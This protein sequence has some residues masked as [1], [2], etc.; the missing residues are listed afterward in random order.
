MIA[1]YKFR[2]YELDQALQVGDEREFDFFVDPHFAADL[3]APIYPGTLLVFANTL[4]GPGTPT[5]SHRCRIVSIRHPALGNVRSISTK[6][7]TYTLTLDDSSTVFVNAEE[8][9]GMIEGSDRQ[10]DDWAFVIEL[11]PLKPGGISH[12]DH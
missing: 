7:F 4:L 3:S 8:Q 5:V 12:T 6:G 1:F 10:I 9:P 11:Q 2:F